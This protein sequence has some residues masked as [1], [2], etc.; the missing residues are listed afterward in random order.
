MLHRDT[1]RDQ[2][3]RVLLARILDGTY[4]PGDRLLELQIARELNASQGS[5][6]EALRQ[7]EALRLLETKTYRG[8][9]VRGVNAREMREA[10]QVRAVLEET[11]A[12]TAAA[13]FKNNA[14]ALQ[15]EVNALRA[16]ARARDP[17]AYA[18]HNLK[19]HRLIV[20]ASG[21]GVLLRVWESLDLE[22]LA[23]ITLAKPSIDLRASAD[24][25]QAIVDALSRGDGKLAGRLLKD[26]AGSCCRHIDEIALP[27]PSLVAHA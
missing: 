1:L 21:N 8:T 20:E 13:K 5:V 25:H 22:V 19:L 4:K 10:Y 16:A 15:T 23:R 27:G 26:H 12:K 17:D 14:A 3:K 9:R 6:R 2:I 18:C 11:A 24:S 7:L